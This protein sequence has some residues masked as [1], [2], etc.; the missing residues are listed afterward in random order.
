MPDGCQNL[1]FLPETAHADRVMGKIALQELQGDL[2]GLTLVER[3]ENGAHAAFAQR[4]K[5][6]VIPVDD[7]PDG[8]H[9]SCVPV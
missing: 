1:A 9:G 8:K 4:G 3:L 5:D 7:G 2:P 6:M